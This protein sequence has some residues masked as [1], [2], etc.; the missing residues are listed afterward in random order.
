M[1]PH[2]PPWFQTKLVFQ[3]KDGKPHAKGIMQL[4]SEFPPLI[5]LSSHRTLSGYLCCDSCTSL[6]PTPDWPVSP[7]VLGSLSSQSTLSTKCFTQQSA[8]IY[9]WNLM[10]VSLSVH[11]FDL[12][13]IMS[14]AHFLWHHSPLDSFRTKPSFCCCCLVAKSCLTLCHPTD[15][16]TPGFP[17][18]HY[19]L[20]FAQIHVCWVSDAI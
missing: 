13:C 17:V 4:K 18:L 11:P 1:L 20:E 12:L 19:L 2:L 8:I 6:K 9:S 15:C 14:Y 7:G 10:A 3:N 5:S 16:S